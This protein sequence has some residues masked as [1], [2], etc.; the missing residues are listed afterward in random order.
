VLLENVAG[1]YTSLLLGSEVFVPP[2]REAGLRGSSE[3]SPTALLRCANAA[4]AHSMILLP[5]MLKALV[6]EVQAT[7]ERLPHARYVAVGGARTAASLLNA[8]REQGIPAYEGYGL[9]ECGSVVCLNT[10]EADSPGTVGQ[11]LGHTRVRIADDG[12]VLVRGPQRLCYAGAPPAED[13]WIATGDIGYQDQAGFIHLLGRK[14]SVIIT[15]FGRNVSPEWVESELLAQP[16]IAQ[17]VVAGDDL[18]GLM[19]LLVMTPGASQE[20]VARSVAAA[21]QQLPDYARVHAWRVVPAFL[22]LPGAMTS[23]GRLRREVITEHY[24]AELAELAVSIDGSPNH[25]K[26]EKKQHGLLPRTA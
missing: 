24:A 19:A 26:K 10:P 1:V 3:F 9:S 25:P 17:A 23:N 15:G 8:A 2:L 5:Q 7:G 6:A 22:A 13:E 16:C 21:N 20:Q 11:P 4:R 14:R 12:E 18:P